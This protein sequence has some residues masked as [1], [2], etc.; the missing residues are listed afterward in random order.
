MDLVILEAEFWT[1]IERIEEIRVFSKQ[2]PLVFRSRAFLIDGAWADKAVLEEYSTT[3]Y[4]EAFMTFEDAKTYPQES[5][6]DSVRECL[7]KVVLESYWEGSAFDAWT[8]TR[9]PV[10]KKVEGSLN[11]E[12][13]GQAQ[14]E[15]A[16]GN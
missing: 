5:K 16:I 8:N 13:G 1:T 14:N 12:D 7:A 2:I 3:V 9:R 10:V 4:V 15:V 6:F 11:Q